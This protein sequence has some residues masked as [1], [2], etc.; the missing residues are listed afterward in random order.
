MLVSCPRCGRVHARGACPLAGSS[1]VPTRR[2]DEQRFRSTA[3]WQRLAAWTKERDR[4]LCLACL[5]DEVPRITTV[6]LSSH[7]I[8]PIRAD[9]ELRLDPGNVITLCPYHHE[10]AESGE[11]PADRLRVWVEQSSKEY[12][13]L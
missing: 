3:A 6:G 5:H 1:H 13:E 12:D 9:W 7:H 4:H 10:L 2:T 11:L 8:T